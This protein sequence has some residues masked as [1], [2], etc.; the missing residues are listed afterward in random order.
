MN[1]IDKENNDC[2]SG[3]SALSQYFSL[4]IIY[5]LFF[6]MKCHHNMNEMEFDCDILY[7]EHKA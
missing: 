3:I 5:F 1:F 7:A 6:L 2:Y 4:E